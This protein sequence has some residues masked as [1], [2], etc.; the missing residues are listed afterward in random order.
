MHIQPPG[1]FA[2]APFLGGY[3][4]EARGGV[5]LSCGET[6]KIGALEGDISNGRKCDQHGLAIR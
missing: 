3:G 5:C 1:W 2:T 6:R 4:K